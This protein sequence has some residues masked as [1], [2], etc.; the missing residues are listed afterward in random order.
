MDGFFHVL[1]IN[2]ARKLFL[3]EE[4]IVVYSFI[5][6]TLEE[7]DY[8]KKMIKKNFDENPIMSPEEEERF[9]LTNSC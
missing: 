8:W 2:L 4:K 5:K 3:T 6:A 1:I 9:Q 7:Y